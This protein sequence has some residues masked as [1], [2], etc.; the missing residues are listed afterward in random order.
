MRKDLL[1]RE[2][3]YVVEGQQQGPI[4]EP[5]LV[6]MLRSGQI[7]RGTMVWTQDM[8]DWAQ[9]DHIEGLIPLALSPPPIPRPAS[10]SSP[11]ASQAL[12][13]AVGPAFLHIPVSRLIVMSIL[14]C[15]LYE[16][17]WIYKNW[18]YLKE[19]DGMNIRPFWRGWF[20]VFYCHSL[21]KTIHQDR[22]L[23]QVEQPNFSPGGLATGWVVLVIVANM[24]GRA[25]AAI[26]SIISFVIPSFLCFVPVQNYINSVNAMKYPNGQHSKWSAGHTVCLI[27]GLLIWGLTLW[28]IG[29]ED[30]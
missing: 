19:R 30:Y 4:P 28:S 7:P 20:G 5:E 21:L 12:S 16:I 9:A 8:Q 17:Y 6:N 10:T 13:S 15:G 25:P 11:A 1:M 18:R 14:S 27:F 26:A 29:V 3:H 2:W 22:E 23:T 24:V